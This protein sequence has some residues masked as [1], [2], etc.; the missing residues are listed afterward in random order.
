MDKNSNEIPVK[1]SHFPPKAYRIQEVYQLLLEACVQIYG[2]SKTE[3]MFTL[4]QSN[5]NLDVEK[6]KSLPE[7]SKHHLV[8]N[9]LDNIK[10]INKPIRELKY[11]Y[12]QPRIKALVQTYLTNNKSE[13][14]KRLENFRILPVYQDFIKSYSE[15][16]KLG[17][18]IELAIAN[19]INK[20]PDYE[21]ELITILFN[22]LLE[23]KGNDETNS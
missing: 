4:L 1:R 2:S 3:L 20:V 16:R 19:F 14:P 11:I 8:E 10:E 21:Y 13:L 5:K 12:E 7:C 23:K 6:L 18:T 22:Y 17:G 15:P 9:M